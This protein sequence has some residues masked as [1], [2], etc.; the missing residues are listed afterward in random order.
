[1]RIIPRV[2]FNF[3]HA[4][5]TPRII[6]FCTCA[7]Y[8][9]YH[10]ILHMRIIPCVSLNFSHAH[11]TPC[12]SQ[13]VHAH[14]THIAFNFAHAQC[15]LY[16]SYHSILH[17]C[18]TPCISFNFAQAQCPLYQSVCACAL[19]ICVCIIFTYIPH[20]SMHMLYVCRAHMHMQDH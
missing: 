8:L 18:I 19:Y 16:P 6:Q 1:M 5:Y 13:F 3:A 14:Y 2:S 11:Y 20:K 10:S 9:V 15:A 7:L 4:H 12:I 17:R